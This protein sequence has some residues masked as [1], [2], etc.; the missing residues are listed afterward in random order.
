[1]LTVPAIGHVDAPAVSLLRMILHNWNDQNCKRG[2]FLLAA[3]SQ[4]SRPCVAKTLS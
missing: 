4:V 3:S 2:V 1:M